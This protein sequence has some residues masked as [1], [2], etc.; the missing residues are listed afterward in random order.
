MTA[1]TLNVLK[2]PVLFVNN[3]NTQT[4]NVKRT[5]FHVSSYVGG[6]Q[7]SYLQITGEVELVVN[8]RQIQ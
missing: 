2:T 6:K 8:K 1:V 5:Y 3:V 7:V 4:N